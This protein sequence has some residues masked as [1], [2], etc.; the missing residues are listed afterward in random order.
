[1]SSALFWFLVVLS[2]FNVIDANPFMLGLKNYNYIVFAE[3][4]YLPDT[5][6]KRVTQKMDAWSA[7]ETERITAESALVM[8]GVS[9]QILWSYNTDMI[10]PSASLTKLMTAIVFLKNINDTSAWQEVVTMKKEDMVNGTRYIYQ[11]E[12]VTVKDLFITSL[13]GS[14]NDATNAMVRS[15]GISIEDYVGFMNNQAR[16]YGLWKTHFQDTTGL[17][18]QNVTT[19]KEAAWLLK[20]ALTYKEI[21]ESLLMDEYVFNTVNTKRFIRIYNTNKLLNSSLNVGG[22]KT[23][24]INASQ[25]NL[26]IKAENATGD[27]VFIVVLGSESDESRFKEIKVLSEWAFENYVWQ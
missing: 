20:E 9:G 19:V 10:W 26:A 4:Q 16:I 24:H 14:I 7:P 2:W 17:S 13:V 6:L 8:D 12:Q 22:G 1:M 5:E 27:S 25:Y 18:Q 15:S 3:N 11:D 23:G 21:Q